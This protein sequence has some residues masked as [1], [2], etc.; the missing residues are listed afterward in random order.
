MLAEKEGDEH[1]A[2]YRVL[3]DVRNTRR[4]LRRGA[5]G[6]A[7][8]FVLIGRDHGKHL[9]PRPA[10]KPRV[11]ESEKM[12]STGHAERGAMVRESAHFL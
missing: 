2:V 5:K 8:H 11:N 3:Q 7:E 12:T 10:E 1:G 6:D 9:S 4:V